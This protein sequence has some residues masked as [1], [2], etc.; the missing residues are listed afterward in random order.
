MDAHLRI[1]AG[2]LREGDRVQLIHPIAGVAVGTAGTILRE[3]AFESFY[4][5]DFDGYGMP[6]LV[7][8]R[9]L[10]RAALNASAA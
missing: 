7:D 9:K 8:K 5:V 1:Y 10:T 4:D 3:Y 2:R 6:H